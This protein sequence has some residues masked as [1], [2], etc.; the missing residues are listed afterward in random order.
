MVF[1][2]KITNKILGRFSSDS[3][4]LDALSNFTIEIKSNQLIQKVSNLKAYMDKQIP[5]SCSLPKN[6]ITIRLIKSE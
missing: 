2:V 3:R 4:V 5:I 1:Y 6:T